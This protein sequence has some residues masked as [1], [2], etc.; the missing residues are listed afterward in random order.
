MTIAI[1]NAFKC[2]K[3]I[4]FRTLG[5]GSLLIIVG[6]SSGIWLGLKSDVVH[7]PQKASSAAEEHLM[8]VDSVPLAA[9]DKSL[10]EG[11]RCALPLRPGN[12]ITAPTLTS[13][14]SDCTQSADANAAVCTAAQI[15]AYSVAVASAE[16]LRL[17]TIVTR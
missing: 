9:S 13:T 16:G 7:L 17:K 14:V 15:P 5:I 11:L 10:I 4:S 6:L 12:A 3:N 8:P 1:E 2:S